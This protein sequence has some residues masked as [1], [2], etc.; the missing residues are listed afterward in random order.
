MPCSLLN[1]RLHAPSSL[2]TLGLVIMN[3]DTQLCGSPPQSTTRFRFNANTHAWQF[4]VTNFRTC[5]KQVDINIFSFNVTI[6]LQ[7]N[8]SLPSLLSGIIS[9]LLYAGSLSL[10]MFCGMYLTESVHRMPLAKFLAYQV[11]APALIHS[12]QQEKSRANKPSQVFLTRA[13]HAYP[14]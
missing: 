8:H 1:S 4:V 13:D 11:N 10:S 3:H 6:H 5:T 14:K 12:H 2:Y 9:L 7:A